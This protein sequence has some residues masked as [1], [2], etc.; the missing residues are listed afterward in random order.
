MPDPDDEEAGVE[1]Q[2]ESDLTLKFNTVRGYITAIQ[3]LYEEQKSK[4]LNFAPYPQGAGIRALKKSI[5]CT[6]WKKKRLAF[7]DRGLGTLKDVYSVS[8]IPDHTRSAWTMKGDPGCLLRT[9]VD[10]LLGNHLLLRASNRRPIE[11][12]D[13]MSIELPNEG[14]NAAQTPTRALILV[15]DHSKTNQHGRID[16]GGVLR[17]REPLSCAVSALAFWLFWRWQAEKKEAFPS[18]ATPQDWYTIK[19]LRRNATAIRGSSLLSR[20][21]DAFVLTAN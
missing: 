9:N 20:G 16:S 6:V 4:Q 2:T 15:E 8:Q 1:L 19:L 12:P 11:L 14:R 17:H 3:K 18:F 5:R 21:H 13:L 7:E 10:F